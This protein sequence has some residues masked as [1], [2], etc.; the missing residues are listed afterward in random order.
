MK[1]FV[2]PLL[3]TIFVLLLV[4]S[5]E[6]VTADHLEPGEGIWKDENHLNLVTT[7]DSK[8]QVHL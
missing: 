2:I 3:G 5:T 6:S 7:K 1:K 4:D 8:Y